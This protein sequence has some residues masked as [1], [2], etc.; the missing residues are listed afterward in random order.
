VRLLHLFA[1]LEVCNALR[2]KSLREELALDSH[3]DKPELRLSDGP[4]PV[5][6]HG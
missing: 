2:L 4:D 6:A 1:E 5:A 3:L